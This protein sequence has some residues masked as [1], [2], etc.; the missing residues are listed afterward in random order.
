MNG[1]LWLLPLFAVGF[2]LRALF[3]LWRMDR[4]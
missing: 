3:R 1:A 2:A 4:N